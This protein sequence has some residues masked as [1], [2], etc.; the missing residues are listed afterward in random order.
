MTAISNCGAVALVTIQRNTPRVFITA[1][2]ALICFHAFNI[3]FF[4]YVNIMLRAGQ[5]VAIS[6]SVYV[7]IKCIAT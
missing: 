4:L 3:P 5:R 6:L 1:F 7:D 2:R